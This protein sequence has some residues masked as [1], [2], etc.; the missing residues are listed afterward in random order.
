MAT[1]RQA[2]GG[3][4]PDPAEA[5]G[6]CE[7]AGA[8]SIVMHLREDRRHIQDA[9]LFKVRSRIGIKVNMEMSIAPSVVKTVL[10]LAPEQATL[11]PERRA[12]R[13]T[14]GGLDLFK[15]SGALERC[16]ADLKR[17]KTAVSLFVDPDPR[18]IGRAAELGVEAVELHTGD[19][20]NQKSAALR[21]RELGRLSTAARLA[22]A[23][24]LN[25][26]AGHGLDYENVFAVKNI[27]EIEELNIGFSIVTRAVRVGLEEAVREMIRLMKR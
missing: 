6:I 24:G 22:R 11:V 2:R 20:A 9:D 18:Q 17:K 21:R 27:A 4:V 16:L 26:Y 12:E 14:E 10:R 5:A 23:K 7:K 13:T 3:A 8:D 1:L 25:V 15:K 19:Y